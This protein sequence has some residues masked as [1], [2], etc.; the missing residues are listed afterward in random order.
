MSTFTIQKPGKLLDPQKHEPT[1]EDLVYSLDGLF[2]EVVMAYLLYEG[3]KP[4][5]EEMIR[6]QLSGQKFLQAQINTYPL[7]HMRSFIYAVD[8]FG[9]H[10]VQ[11]KSK[12]DASSA[13][14]NLHNVFEQYFFECTAVRNSIQ[15]LE[16]RV[17]GKARN[18]PIPLQGPLILN[19]RVDDNFICT[20][21]DGNVGSVP[22]TE[23]SVSFLQSI[24]QQVL[25]SFDWIM[26]P[27]TVVYGTPSAQVEREALICQM[28]PMAM[29]LAQ[30]DEAFAQDQIARLPQRHATVVSEL[31]K[32]LRTQPSENQD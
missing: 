15:H 26:S 17:Q 8:M 18:K 30:E 24:Y 11:L 4:N 10:L 5:L 29:S 16:D 22:V 14:S 2:D 1:T 23:G 12:P 25:N 20:M 27:A 3:T 32:V 31:V 9:K 28:M 6:L 21:N 13:I 19:S 7:M